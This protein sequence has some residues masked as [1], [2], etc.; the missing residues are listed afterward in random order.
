MLI[1]IVNARVG[2]ASAWHRFLA[3]AV[4]PFGAFLVLPF[5]VVRSSGIGLVRI[6]AFC[7]SQSTAAAV[8]QVDCTTWSKAASPTGS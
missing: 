8:K 6:I 5:S 7:S 3:L 2:D 4:G 1:E